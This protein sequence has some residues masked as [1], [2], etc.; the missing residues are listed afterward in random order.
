MEQAVYVP[1]PDS[2]KQSQVIFLDYVNKYLGG[3]NDK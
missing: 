2:Y 1:D 3:N